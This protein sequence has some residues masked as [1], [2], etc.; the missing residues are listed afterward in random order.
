MGEPELYSGEKILIRTMGVRVKSISF[1]AILTNK[2]IIL[3]DR[4]KNLL[5]PKEIPLA[6]IRTVDVGENAIRD[7][8]IMLMVS[9]K[10]DRMRQMV[11]TFSREGGGNRAKERNDWVQLIMENISPSYAGTAPS[12][13]IAPEEQ[14]DPFTPSKFRYGGSMIPPTQ[15]TRPHPVKTIVEQ[16]PQETREAPVPTYEPAPVYSPDSIIGTYCTRCGT[17]VP[18]SSGFCNKCG[19]RI[20]GPDEIPPHAAI[21]TPPVQA[22]K[23]DF[24]PL[25]K[26]HAEDEFL[27]TPH[28]APSRETVQTFPP[29]R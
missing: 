17:K 24:P 2:R 12:T 11:L 1:E 15:A 6:T 4:I 28:V 9:T 19:S 10:S 7:S 21:P 13:G 5:P 3:V 29:S 23:R 16:T 26:I 27:A 18:E 14:P 8:I 20:I 25:M 22:V